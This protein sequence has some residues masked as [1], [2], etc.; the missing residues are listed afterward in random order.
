MSIC[1]AAV[2]LIARLILNPVD[3]LS[4]VVVRDEIL[5]IRLTGKSAMIT[6]DSGTQKVPETAEIVALSDF[7]SYDS[8]QYYYLLQTK[9]LG[10]KP[11]TIICGLYVGDDFDNAYRI[12]YGLKY[13]S[14][15]R[16]RGVK[17]G[18]GK[19]ERSGERR[20]NQFK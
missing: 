18:L 15:L 20:L 5:G 7:H 9:A 11:A 13:W 14:S 2:E 6:G 12:T 1:L 10:L 19:C 17:R 16:W 4:P 8:N 3:Y